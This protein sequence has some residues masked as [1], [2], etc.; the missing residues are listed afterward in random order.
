MRCAPAVR[1][2][3]APHVQPGAQRAHRADP[4]HAVVGRARVAGVAPWRRARRPVDGGVDEPGVGPRPA[5][6]EQLVAD[7][8]AG[9]LL[10]AGEAPIG[11]PIVASPLG[12]PVPGKE[13]LVVRRPVGGVV[14]VQRRVADRR[15]ILVE[16]A[17]IEPVCE[18]LGP[19]WMSGEE[20]EQIGRHEV[21]ELRQQLPVPCRAD[22]D[23]LTLRVVRRH[24][25]SAARVAQEHDPLDALLARAIGCRRRSRPGRGR[26]GSTARRRGTACSTQGSRSRERPCS[27]PG[28]ARRSR[29]CS[30][31]R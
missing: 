7:A 6:D 29:C 24:Q 16:H 9:Q 25:R 26:G 15:I 18:D 27:R 1:L 2:P 21:I 19:A 8:M 17:R 11:E 22:R 13:R 12:G 20:H 4:E 30:G 3:K 5:H 28:S 23:A 10:Q 31:S 14:H